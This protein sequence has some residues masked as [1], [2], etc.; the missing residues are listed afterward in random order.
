MGVDSIPVPIGKISISRW[1]KKIN[2]LGI[3][4]AAVLLLLLAYTLGESDWVRVPPP[5]FFVSLM[6]VINGWLLSKT[7][8]RMAW[9]VVYSFL[10]AL[11]FGIQYV[12]KIVPGVNGMQVYDW[13]EITNW[14]IFL[15]LERANSWLQSIQTQKIIYDEG[16]W[17][18]VLIAMVWVSTSWLVTCLNSR[19]SYW[20]ALLPLMGS[21]AFVLQNDRKDV[22]ILL[23]A[24]FLGIVL[25]THG[26]YSQKQKNWH[27]RRIDFPE[28][29]WIDWYVAMIVISIVVLFAANLAPTFTTQEGWREIRNW[30][31]EMTTPKSSP[32]KDAGLGGYVYRPPETRDEQLLLLQPLDL[33]RVGDPL[34][35]MEGTVMWVRTGDVTPRPWRMA[36]YSTYTGSGW[37]EAELDEQSNVLLEEA[38]QQ[39][40][41][42][43]YQR[44]TLFRAAGGRLFSAAEP[45]QTL[46]EDVRLVSLVDDDSQIVTGFVQHYEV[47][48][49]VPDLSSEM[50]Q[51]ASGEIPK[52]IQEEYLQLPETTPRRVR[53]LAAR[54]VEGQNTVYE[55][56]IQIQDYVRQSVP[57]D[58]ESVPP[59]RDQDVVD[60][61]LFEA[62]SGFCT[63]YASAMAV[64]LRIEG[65]PARLVTGYAPGEF[66]PEQGNFE[67][68]GDLAH[69][70]VEVYFPGY[71]WIPFEPTPSQSVPAYSYLNSDLADMNPEIPVTQQGNQRWIYLQILIGGL[72][73]CGVVWLGRLLVRFIRSRRQEKKM[74]LHPAA[75][76]YRRLRINLANA[77]VIG[78]PSLTPREFLEL[79][80]GKL[81]HYPQVKDALRVGT[82]IYEQTIYSSLTPKVEDINLLRNSIKKSN[83]ERIKLRLRYVLNQINRKLMSSRS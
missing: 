58:L 52:S 82:E 28:Q 76:A 11:S 12:G 33:S 2:W 70:W 60:Y 22:F 79:V 30:V 77:G 34:P 4:I 5:L 69:A 74:A 38:P 24:L 35:R 62:N 3:L 40:R 17:T 37:V 43:L 32:E 49:W 80:E 36:I 47:I 41:K 18:M 31:E 56:V 59:A 13:L 78:A 45:V 26:H 19:K 27:W 46:N 63:Y 29:L 65:I 57:Y 7:R 10:M 50:L 81:V 72:I 73:V 8:W 55:Q 23:A 16:F 21:I 44:F 83:L 54:L 9:G 20:I 6:A 61:F 66:V 67:V 64:L 71:G 68:T 39:G 14:Q 15:F 53:N 75:L 42:A 51:T 25:I 48:S 1:I